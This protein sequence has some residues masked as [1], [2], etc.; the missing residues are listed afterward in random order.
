M[1]DFESVELCKEASEQFVGGLADVLGFEFFLVVGTLVD[2]VG[3]LG[4]VVR[5]LRQS[6]KALIHIK[7]GVRQG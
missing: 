3:I 5:M 7:V 4:R 6:V 2:S 1:V